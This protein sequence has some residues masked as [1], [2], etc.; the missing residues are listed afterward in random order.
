MSLVI[1][2]RTTNPRDV[3]F[4]S[5]GRELAHIR[6]TDSDDPENSAPIREDFI[7][8]LRLNSKVALAVTGGVEPLRMF[9]AKLL[10]SVPWDRCPSDLP[11]TNFAD[12]VSGGGDLLGG[13]L[14]DIRDRVQGIL[15]EVSGSSEDFAELNVVVGGECHGMLAVFHYPQ[16]R[17]FEATQCDFV[18]GKPPG[19]RP[20][21]RFGQ[22]KDIIDYYLDEQGLL[23][24]D[25]EGLCCRAIRSFAQ[26]SFAVNDRCMLRRLSEGFALRLAGV[27]NSPACNA[28]G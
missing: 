19:F 22:E 7:K 21:V 24:P 28:R 12:E 11:P 16:P 23:S 4:V 1:A 15:S 26:H 18:W 3:I 2:V 20:S 8:T 6:T 9:L 5:D 13:D 14:P 17:G 27:D 25:V 10:P